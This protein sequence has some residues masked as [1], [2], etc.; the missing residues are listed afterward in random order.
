MIRAGTSTLA[1]FRLARRLAT[2]VSQGAPASSVPPTRH[3]WS[4]K[5]I[6]EIYDG[7]LLDLVFRAAAVHRQ[8]H[9]PKKIQLCTLMNIKSALSFASATITFVGLITSRAS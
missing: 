3:D 4:R 5:E 2:H 7:P 1:S 9:D 8:Y 6:K